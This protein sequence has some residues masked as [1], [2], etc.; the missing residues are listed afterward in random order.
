MS[1]DKNSWNTFT[2][3]GWVAVERGCSSHQKT[4]E[5]GDD[6]K[7]LNFAQKLVAEF[8]HPWCILVQKV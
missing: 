3:M 4:K 6:K 2:V 1:C 7:C 8:E 5:Q